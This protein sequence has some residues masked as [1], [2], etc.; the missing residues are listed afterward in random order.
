MYEHP[1]PVLI[2]NPVTD[3]GFVE[4]ARSL[5]SDH[6]TPV[7]LQSALR[8]RYPQAIVRRRELADIDEAW[9]VYRDGRWVSSA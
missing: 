5:A 6:Q 8:T 4:Y 7:E 1:R 9:Y 2:L 3:P